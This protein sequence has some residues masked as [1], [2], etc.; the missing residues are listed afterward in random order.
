MVAEWGLWVAALLVVTR[1]RRSSGDLRRS[2]EVKMVA[3]VA[4]ESP[5]LVHWV[6]APCL[7]VFLGFVRVAAEVQRAVVLG[8]EVRS[9]VLLLWQVSGVCSGE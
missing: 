8:Y 3:L 4:S 6:L 7:S 5:T 2:L 9:I 1:S